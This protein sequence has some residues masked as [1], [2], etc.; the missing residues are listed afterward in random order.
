MLSKMVSFK[1]GDK[2]KFDILHN[3]LLCTS[4]LKLYNCDANQ[5]R[6][7]EEILPVMEKQ[8]AKERSLFSAQNFPF[9]TINISSHYTVLTAQIGWKWSSLK[10]FTSERLKYI[11]ICL[12][13]WTSTNACIS[14]VGMNHF[15]HR[16]F[17]KQKNLLWEVTLFQGV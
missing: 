2:C 12:N 3:F 11:Y 13:C 6:C 7:W 9:H 15:S 16:N 5:E 4:I 1:E 14:C 8:I 17:F 10:V